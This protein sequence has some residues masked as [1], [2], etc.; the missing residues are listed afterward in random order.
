M[1]LPTRPLTAAMER[2]GVNFVRN[3][4]E[5]N[6]CIFHE[7]HH[8]ND[9]GNDAFVEL[10][11]GQQVTGRCVGV[12]IKAGDSYLTTSTCRIPYTAKQATYWSNHSLRVLGVVYDPGQ[13]VAYWINLGARSKNLST[14]GTLT[15]D[16]SEFRR[17]TED[18]FGAIV[19][20]L[21][22]GK[23]AIL[24]QERARSYAVSAEPEAKAIG[25]RTLLYDHHNSLD[26]W[27]FFHQLLIDPPAGEPNPFLAHALAH[28]PW[29]GDIAWF[30]GE[31]DERVRKQVRGEMNH[32]GRPELQGLLAM[33]DENGIERGSVGQSV[34]A[35]IDQAVDAADAKLVEIAF[36]RGTHREIRE[37]AL[38]L[39]CF[40]KQDGLSP[41]LDRAL[42][43]EVLTDLAGRMQAHLREFGFFA[44]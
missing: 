38:Y 39:L 28:I 4:V 23:R 9:Y 10:V 34:Y 3:V 44:V 27:K 19:L 6:N 22:L 15:F 32:W 24:T 35:I 30:G 29:H 42:A 20:P 41:V 36:D 2:E 11:D 14:T 40:V 25:L 31:I 37:R 13:Q 21:L 43:D 8:E 1:E 12:Q 5:K 33:M 18:T 16:R 7:I 26:T 17:L